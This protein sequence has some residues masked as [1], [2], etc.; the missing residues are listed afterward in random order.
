MPTYS[1]DY[2]TSVVNAMLADLGED[3]DGL[4]GK[5]VVLAWLRQNLRSSMVRAGR[6]TLGSPTALEAARGVAEA[7]LRDEQ[8]ARKAAE[9]SADTQAAVDIGRIA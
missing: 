4:V 1:I 7:A 6:R 8:A 2:P 5:A 9:D 3:G